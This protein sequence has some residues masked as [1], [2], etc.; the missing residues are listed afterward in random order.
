MR[1]FAVSSSE[2]KQLV[3]VTSDDGG[4][5]HA[6]LASQKLLVTARPAAFCWYLQLKAGSVSA[7]LLSQITS[8][9][10]KAKHKT[11]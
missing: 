2:G 9:R 3:I 1:A 7:E 4:I 10:A 5:A 8:W 6:Q 11:C